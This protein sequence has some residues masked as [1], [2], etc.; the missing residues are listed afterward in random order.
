MVTKC[1]GSENLEVL[2]FLGSRQ[3]VFADPY[4][5]QTMRATEKNITVAGDIIVERYGICLTTQR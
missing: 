3:K 4:N 2:Y 5:I 1:L